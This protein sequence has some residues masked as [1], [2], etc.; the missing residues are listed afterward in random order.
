MNKLLF[1]SLFTFCLG[2]A[3]NQRFSYVSKAILEKEI[4]ATGSMNVK[5][6]MRKGLFRHV[7]I[8][9]SPDFKTFLMTLRNGQ[10]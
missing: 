6:D 7:I 4:T 2:N 5:S 9:E 8:K 3:Q 1:L 10:G